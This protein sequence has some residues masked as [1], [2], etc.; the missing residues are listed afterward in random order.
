MTLGLTSTGAVKIKTDGGLRAV[1]CTCCCSLVTIPAELAD[2]I[3][4]KTSVRATFNFPAFDCDG[5]P[6]SAVIGDTGILA[7]DGTFVFWRDYTVMDLPAF[8]MYRLSKNC[9]IFFFEEN[10]IAYRRV[11]MA[12][13]AFGQSIQIPINGINVFATQTNEN[14]SFFGIP[15]SCC[16]LPSMTITF[17]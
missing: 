7:W 5:F 13:G 10:G 1:E 11:N 12:R 8:T 3:E 6:V 15:L 17:S 16:P 2:V 14:E 4:G 9:I